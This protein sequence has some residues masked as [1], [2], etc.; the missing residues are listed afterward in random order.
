MELSICLKF[1]SAH[2]GYDDQ[3]FKINDTLHK[4]YDL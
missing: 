2:I 1:K 4:K 3:V